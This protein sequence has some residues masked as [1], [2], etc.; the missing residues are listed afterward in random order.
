MV[1]ERNR[2]VE[3][4]NFLNSIGLEVNIGKTKARG[5]NGVFIRKGSCYRIDI[6]K[7]VAQSKIES[8]ILHEFAHY[9]HSLYDKNLSDLSFIFGKVSDIE[10]EE[11][12]KVTVQEVPKEFAQELCLQKD[13]ITK[14][15]KKIAESLNE[16][17][18]S[19]KLSS[20][21]KEIERLMSRPL[22]YLLKYDQVMYNNQI[23]SIQLL[24][25]S[26]SV[27]NEILLYLKLKSKQ[28]L[29]RRL[30]NKISKLNKYY[31]NPSELF[32]RFFG[33]YFTNNILSK[34]LAPS[35]SK[36]MSD[37]IEQRGV[38][39]LREVAEIYKN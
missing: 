12:L 8:V 22:K 28:R 30:T 3:L 7:A 35:I 26:G 19:F 15:V 39:Y 20:P 6:S 1:S 24:E 25:A 13:L 10:L 31:N 16:I 21:C 34:E 23:Y 33:L 27:S 4:S 17:Y 38:L 37:I 11:L 5:N 18:P 32:A 2:I 14:D 36:K 9:I 29:L